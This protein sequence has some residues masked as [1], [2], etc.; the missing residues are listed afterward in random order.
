[1]AHPN[2]D[3][4]LDEGMQTA[5][6]FL[7]KNGEFFPFGVTMAPDGSLAHAQGY[8]GD[9]CPPSQEVIDLLLRG[10]NTGAA[11][12]DYKSTALISDVRITL[13]GETKSDAISVTVEHVDDQPVTCFLPYTKSNGTFE[14][15]EIVAERAERRVFNG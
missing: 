13:D 8:T 2:M 4:L 3:A 7:E 11:S 5:I 10:F 6:H 15:G 9:E 14:F 1:M 12:G